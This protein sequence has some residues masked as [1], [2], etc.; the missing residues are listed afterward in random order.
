MLLSRSNLPLCAT[1][2]SNHTLP[3]HLHYI[4]LH[5]ALCTVVSS[6][7]QHSPGQVATA[8]ERMHTLGTQPWGMMLST[9]EEGEAG[10]GVVEGVEGT[11]SRYGVVL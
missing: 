10:E 2:T 1:F 9:E 7:E 4:T 5:T 8:V 11:M 6:R 3:I